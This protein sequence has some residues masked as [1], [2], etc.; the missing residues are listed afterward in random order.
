MTKNEKKF[1]ELT[2]KYSDYNL[3]NYWLYSYHK[4]YD[5][6]GYF[7]KKEYVSWFY[8]IYDRD[9]IYEEYEF[10]DLDELLD[11]NHPY[12]ILP[13]GRTVYQFLKDIDFNVNL[14]FEASIKDN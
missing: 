14:D 8:F 1:R 6:D 9:G 10:A 4:Y 13:D 7:L 11:P 3:P 2:A 12:N 5:K